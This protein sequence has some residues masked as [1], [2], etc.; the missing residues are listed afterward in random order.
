M[1]DTVT[2]RVTARPK[3][4]TFV[5]STPVLYLDDSGVWHHIPAGTPIPVLDTPT[6]EVVK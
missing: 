1:S 4:E 3:K 6:I 2:Y 5:T